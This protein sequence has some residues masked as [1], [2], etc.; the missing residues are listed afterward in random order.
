MAY[1]G[2][3]GGTVFSALKVVDTAFRRCRLPAQ[4]I[5]A[6]MQQYALDA[7]YLLLSNQANLI[8]PS[9]C[10]DKQI[11]PFYQGQPV[12]TLPV[13][14]VEVLNVNFRQLQ[15]VVGSIVTDATHYTNYVSGGA[16]IS[17]VGWT[18]GS[19][20]IAVTFEVSDDAITWL[21]VGAAPA[22]AVA[23][24]RVWYDITPAL[25]Y[26]YFRITALTTLNIVA[27]VMGNLPSEIP[28]GVLNRDTYTQQSNLI[29]Q[30]QP[31]TY[32]FQRDLPLPQLNLWPAPN[33]AS[34]YSGQLIVWRHRQIMD[35]QNLRQEV[36][37]PARWLDAVCSGL[38]FKVAEETPQVDAN[39]VPVLE[40]RW[41]AARQLAMDGDGDGSPIFIQPMIN[42][43]TR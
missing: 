31:T 24:S 26:A 4:S 9:W 29:F 41:L 40:Q 38:A 14:T 5:T 18:W 19:T 2:A 32:W 13:G 7:L 30:G 21:E 17:T 27:V 12:A 43:Y 25:A 33:L 3:I 34:E 37:V 15:Q 39:L 35:T 10:I 28:F 6:E 11:L 1:S 16:S 22:G 8:T 20:G 36:E 42:G 23:G